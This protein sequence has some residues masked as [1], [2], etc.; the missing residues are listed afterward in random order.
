MAR[1]ERRPGTIYSVLPPNMKGFEGALA[2][3]EDEIVIFGAASE[4]FSQKNIN[5]SIAESIARFE[6]VVQAAREAGMTR[7]ISARVSSHET[8][9]LLVARGMGVAV[10][11]HYLKARLA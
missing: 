11:P 3:R 7:R 2:A 1:I 5:C 8:I 4:A 10:V 6:P 9:C